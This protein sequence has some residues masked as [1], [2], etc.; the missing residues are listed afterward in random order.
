MVKKKLSNYI[1]FENFI[2]IFYIQSFIKIN[3]LVLSLSL[4]KVLYVFK[5]WGLKKKR[6]PLETFTIFIFKKIRNLKK[7]Y[8]FFLINSS[9]FIKFTSFNK[10]FKFFMKR[11]IFHIFNYLLFEKK[12]IKFILNW[13]SSFNGCR[14]KKKKRKKRKKRK[15]IF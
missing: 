9:F 14:L 7:N 10:K 13:T 4:N 8:S 15:R 5:T 3:N 2:S 11:F 12:V 1:F 6:K